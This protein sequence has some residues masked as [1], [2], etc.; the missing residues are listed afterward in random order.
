MDDKEE[1]EQEQSYV[2]QDAVVIETDVEDLAF[3]M[4]IVEALS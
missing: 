4:E 3:T 1:V 2:P